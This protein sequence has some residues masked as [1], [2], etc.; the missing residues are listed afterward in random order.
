MSS[1]M[2]DAR[3]V[4]IPGSAYDRVNVPNGSKC[5][6]RICRFVLL[7]AVLC[8]WMLFCVVGCCFVLLDA[9]LCCWM[10]FCVVGCCCV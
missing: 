8:F 7:G 10:L 9:V 1:M 5:C 6:C 3:E 4:L 2:A